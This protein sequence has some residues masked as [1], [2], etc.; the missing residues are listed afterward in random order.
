MT[1]WVSEPLLKIKAY[2]TCKNQMTNNRSNKGFLHVS[3]YPHIRL[4][5][6]LFDISRK[7][8]MQSGLGTLFSLLFSLVLKRE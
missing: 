4:L 6:S 2:D 3:K 5:N 1:S 7:Q 8:R